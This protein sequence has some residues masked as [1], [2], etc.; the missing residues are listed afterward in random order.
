MK[1]LLFHSIVVL[2]GLAAVSCTTL[3]GVDGDYGL[4]PEDAGTDTSAAGQGGQA[5]AG[6]SGGEAGTSSGGAAGNGAGGVSGSGGSGGASG[7][8][9]AAGSSPG[10]AS[11][12]GGDAGASGAGGQGGGGVVSPLSSMRSG[13]GT[14]AAETDALSLTIPAVDP[15]KSFLMFGNR[16]AFGDPPSTLVSGQ[17]ESSTKL[18]FQRLNAVGTTAIPISW[19]VASFESGVSVQRGATSHAGTSTAVTLPTPVQL[20]KAFPLITVRG[21][22]NYYGPF[23]YVRASLTNAQTLTIDTALAQADTIVE[24]QVVSFEGATVRS[25]TVSFGAAD[26]TKTATTTGADP[27]RTWLL[28]TYYLGSFSG[29]GLEDRLFRGQVT[30]DTQLEF[31]RQAPDSASAELR[32]YTVTFDNGSRVE[33]GS[34]HFAGTTTSLQAPVA[35]PVD[36]TRSLVSAGGIYYRGGTSDS[37]SSMPGV[38]CA[39]LEIGG[40]DSV[41]VSRAS[42]GGGGA[43]TDINWWAVEFK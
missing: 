18:S 42:P 26:A 6:G 24:W 40:G 5:G 1:R 15:A 39:T 30:S 3:L 11:G 34:A 25:G 13:T 19:Y 2:A 14:L 21:G 31:T 33:T 43:V 20:D 17:L 27:S 32:W 8:G 12:A 37:G 41:L 35:K 23:S 22:G 36:P 38:A 16:F 7:A 10:G 4:L 29:S 28:F 9:G